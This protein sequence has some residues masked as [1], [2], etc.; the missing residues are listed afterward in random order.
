M[1]IDSTVEPKNTLTVSFVE[2]WGDPIPSSREQS[3]ASGYDSLSSET[4]NTESGNDNSRSSRQL[5]GVVQRLKSLLLKG[6]EQI[7]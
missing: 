1:S 6:R 4:G 3:R 2:V 5:A 7:S